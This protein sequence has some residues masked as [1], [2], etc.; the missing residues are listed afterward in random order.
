MTNT[1]KTDN[2]KEKIKQAGASTPAEKKTATIDPVK[3]VQ[4]YLKA[5][6]PRIKDALPR[7]MDVNKLTQ[8][9]V[10]TLRMNPAL[11]NCT[12]ESLLGAVMQSAQLGLTPDLMGSCFFV[13]FKN[14]V[15]FIVGYR[16][17]IDLARRSG[18]VLTIT[19]QLVYEH[20]FFDFEWGLNE[21]LRHIPVRGDRGEI[22]YVYAYAKLKNGGHAFEVMPIEDILK[23]RD[24]H[25]ASYKFQKDNSIWGKHFD[26][27]CKKTCIKQLIKLLPISVE[28][29]NQVERDETVRKD[30]LSDPERVDVIDMEFDSEEASA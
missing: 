9:T 10:T 17:M 1:A 26:A 2:L 16:G 23:I 5:M 7:H 18:E 30:I 19:S 11:Q 3:T 15:Q 22:I 24:E 21:K 20:D 29:Q 28:I 14:Q 8:I 12:I 25:S 6:A 13:P 27:M 4:A